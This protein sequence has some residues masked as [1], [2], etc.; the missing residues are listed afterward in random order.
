MNSEL[1]AFGLGVVAT[2]IGRLVDVRL[3]LSHEKRR[4]YSKI[5]FNLMDVHWF[6]SQ[7]KTLEKQNSELYD[8][9]LEKA[10]ERGK[11]N[12]ADILNETE[13]IKGVKKAASTALY[14]LLIKSNRLESAR[15]RMSGTIEQLA[16]IDAYIAYK[17]HELLHQ[18]IRVSSS[19]EYLDEYIKNLPEYVKHGNVEKFADGFQG[20][21]KEVLSEFIQDVERMIFRINRK[22]QFPLSRKYLLS[23]KQ[24]KK[25]INSNNSYEF[26][27]DKVQK[28]FELIFGMQR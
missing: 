15:E 23:T 21:E 13:T 19:G 24:L 14:L 2:V 5:L 4:R 26:D 8:L 12:R 3:A 28:I 27:P 11:V 16:E 7:Y 10:I 20:I 25:E 22:I 6:L 1:I 17:L 18:I 9:L